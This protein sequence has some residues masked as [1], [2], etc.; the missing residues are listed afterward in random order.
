VYRLNENK[1]EWVFY[2]SE[3]D[4]SSVATAA[5]R[6]G[7]YGVFSDRVPPRVHQPVVGTWKSY[8]TGRT[9]PEIAIEIEDNGSGVDYEK[10]S[11][12][13]DGDQQI[14]YWDNPRK[15]LFV[16]VRGDNIMGRRELLITAFDKIG[17]KTV[18]QTSIEI[19]ANRQPQGKSR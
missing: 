5:K 7:V 16:V 17:N 9:L 3:T 14:F 10:T 13:L 8:A 15:K 11:V 2:P 4:K 19:P 6:P 18:R 1:P 12:L